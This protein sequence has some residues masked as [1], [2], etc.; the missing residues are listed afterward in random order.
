MA[1]GILWDFDVFQMSIV[2]REIIYHF[3]SIE[4]T[5]RVEIIPLEPEQRSDLRREAPSVT[6]FT[7]PL[8]EG[9]RQ[10]ILTFYLNV[11]KARL[12]TSAIFYAFFCLI[13]L[14][15]MLS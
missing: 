7:L 3:E 14:H 4:R 6:S 1:A 10:K 2:S 12:Q 8:F 13:S 11:A 5:A 9:P 15:V